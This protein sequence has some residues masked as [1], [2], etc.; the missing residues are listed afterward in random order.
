[1]RLQ[2]LN[3]LDVERY[4]QRDSRIMLVIG[5]TEQHGYLSLLTDALIPARIAEAAAARE[6]VLIA[7][8]LNFGVSGEFVD[9]PGTITLSRT[10][11]EAAVTEIVEGLLYQGFGRFLILNG[12]G[13]NTQPARLRDLDMD[14]AARIV[15]FE[16]WRSAAA[17][18]FEDQHGL[19]IDHA[20]WGE[21]FPF[22]RVGD[23]PTGEKTPVNLALLNEGQLSRDVLGDGVF[24]GR[25]QLD[26]ER[27]LALFEALVEEVVSEL[28]ALD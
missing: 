1:M 7:P 21:N 25:Y 6:P 5:A 3:W 8:P 22:T 10:T 12:H 18:A 24:G 9:Y 26:D 14:G 15:W 27:M 2:D 23:V 19:R 13:G 20:N 11:F 28:R 17:R 4:V 16:W